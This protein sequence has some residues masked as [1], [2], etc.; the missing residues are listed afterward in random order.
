MMTVH[1]DFLRARL[2]ELK[3]LAERA[4]PA[5]RA[6][7]EGTAL[8]FSRAIETI[9]KGREAAQRTRVLLD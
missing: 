2:D 9:A 5:E 1:L 8:V 3:L 6:R 7:L 4:P